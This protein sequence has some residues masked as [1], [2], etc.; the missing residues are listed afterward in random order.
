M[1]VGVYIE[2]LENIWL[3]MFIFLHIFRSAKIEHF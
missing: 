3:K 1:C 2:Y